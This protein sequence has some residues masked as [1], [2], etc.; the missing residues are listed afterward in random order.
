[1][2]KAA[3]FAV[4]VHGSGTIAAKPTAAFTHLSTSTAPSLTSSSPAPFLSMSLT[5]L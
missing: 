4:L 2:G 1:V 5:V 3:P